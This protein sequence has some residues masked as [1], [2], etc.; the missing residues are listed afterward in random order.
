VRKAFSFGLLMAGM[1]V[2]SGYLLSKASLVGRVGIRLF[3]QEY[4]FLAVWWKGALVVAIV[5]LFLFLVQRWLQRKVAPKRAKAA[6]L[7][8]IALALAGLYL[9]YA[10]FRQTLSHRLLGERFHL[11][12]YLFWIGWIAISLYFLTSSPRIYQAHASERWD[13]PVPP[14]RP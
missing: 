13:T 6:H 9:T 8:C 5:W 12:A 4:R 14:E 2:L 11:G 10:D 3:Y 7:L 1:A